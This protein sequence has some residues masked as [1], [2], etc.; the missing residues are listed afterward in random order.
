MLL[1][2][3]MATAAAKIPR[4]CVAPHDKYPFCDHTK[5][6]EDRVDDLVSRLKLE[7][8]PAMLTARQS[9]LGNVSRLCVRRT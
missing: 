7:E 4:A 1:A 3:F 8:K 9:P 2:L 6:M 5:P